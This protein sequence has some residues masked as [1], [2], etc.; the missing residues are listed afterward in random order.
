M[1]VSEVA[2]PI[3]IG[4]VPIDFELI[5]D[6]IGSCFSLVRRSTDSNRKTG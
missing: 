5:E 2:V 1:D 3:T 6:D 4:L